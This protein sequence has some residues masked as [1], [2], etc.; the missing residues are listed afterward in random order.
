MTDWRK[1]RRKKKNKNKQP[2]E[3]CHLGFVASLIIDFWCNAMC[4]QSFRCGL[5]IVDTRALYI[6]IMLASSEHT[7]I[8]YAHSIQ[9]NRLKIGTILHFHS[10]SFA[11]SARIEH[12]LAKQKKYIFISVYQ[13]NKCNVRSALNLNVIIRLSTVM[14]PVRWKLEIDQNETDQK[15][16]VNL[17]KCNHLPNQSL[18][19][20][21]A[22]CYESTDGRGTQTRKKNPNKIDNSA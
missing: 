12:F 17:I 10:F 5:C 2:T 11:D 14:F 20:W 15:G 18:N 4:L 22:F 21:K 9:F 19:L 16:S 8:H 7:D 1:N 3:Q 13:C 6:W